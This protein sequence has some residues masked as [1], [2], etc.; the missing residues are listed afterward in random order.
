MRV[1]KWTMAVLAAGLIAGTAGTASADGWRGHGGFYGH[2]NDHDYRHRHGHA[3]HGV[4]KYVYDDGYC[5]TVIKRR[6][7]RTREVVRCRPHGY[8]QVG[9]TAWPVQRGGDTIVW[10]QPGAEAQAQ[11]QTQAGP[12]NRYCREFQ[13]SAT[14]GGD[15]RQV[16]GQ[17]CRQPDGAWEIVR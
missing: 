11:T 9:H 14:V 13:G 2:Y 4:H 12:D 6:G 1:T 3:R 5:R 10:N 8:G 17:A 7:H 15:A 16:Y